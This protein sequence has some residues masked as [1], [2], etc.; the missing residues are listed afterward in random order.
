MNLAQLRAFD[1]VA[2]AGSFTAAARRL[3]VTQPAVTSHVRALEGYYE[4]D[5]FRRRGRG[6]EP[7][8]LGEHLA[9]ISRRLFALE[10]DAVELLRATKALERGSLRVSADG[11]YFAVPLVA[12]FRERYP[13]V[14]ISMSIDNSARIVDNLLEERC[15]VGVLPAT[16][17][18]ERMHTATLAHHRT[19]LFVS[20]RHEWATAG[21]RRVSIRELDRRR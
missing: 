2:R 18:D 1:A 6:V 11:P 17:V 21:R 3:H 14:R 10:D 5:L 4:V 13:G 15:D 19:V 12:A 7:T 16:D 8:E 20:A 9:A